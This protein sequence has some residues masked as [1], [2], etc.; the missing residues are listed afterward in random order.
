MRLNDLDTTNAL[1]LDLAQALIGAVTPNFR[2]VYLHAKEDSIELFFVLEHDD[3]VDKEEIEDIE[4]EFEALVGRLIDVDL[5]VLIDRRPLSEMNLP[6]R[7]VYA[8]REVWSTD[9]PNA[10]S[11]QNR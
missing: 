6:G 11:P 8:R 10:D 5:F 7:I 1:V 3:P 2:A 4:F 9:T